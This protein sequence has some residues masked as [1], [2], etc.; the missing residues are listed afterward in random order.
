[1][2]KETVIS[3]KTIEA[4]VEQGAAELGTDLASVEFEVLEQ[5]SKGFLGIGASNAKVRVYIQVTPASKAVAFMETVL[6][7]MGLT[8]Q[9]SVKEEKEDE[10]TLVVSGKGLGSLIGRHGDVLDSL[11]YLASLAANRVYDGFYRITLDVEGYREKREETLR[12]LAQ[13]QAEKVLKFKR[14][15]ALEPMNPYERRIIHTE[16]QKI[17]GV[18]TYSIGQDTERRIVI[19]LEGKEKNRK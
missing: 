11:Q 12:R 4:A 9:V 19:C 14:S 8:A 18:A 6:V 5:P 2:V 13:K 10:A 16:I 15:F 17:A 7:D 3:A 1:M